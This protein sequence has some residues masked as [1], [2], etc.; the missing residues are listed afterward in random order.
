[1]VCEKI[2]SGIDMACTAYPRRYFQ[3]AVLVNRSDIEEK[4]ILTSYVNIDDEY[5]CRH[6]VLFK[7]FDG[8][9]GFRFKLGENASSIYGTAEKSI[10]NGIPQYAH[11]VNIAVLGVSEAS[12]CVLGQMDYS[13]YFVALQLYDGTVEIFGFEYGLTTEDYTYD[14]QN[15]GGGAVLKLASFE[16]SLEDELPFIYR[17]GTEGGENA[18]FDNL[19]LNNEFNVT[20]DFN[21][22]F[23]DDY[24]NQS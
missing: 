20:G 21:D 2:R 9:S 7:L 19:F 23:N 16:D 8:L 14:P 15:S 18:D 17:S 24:N 11:S 12:K 3:Q 22:D 6:R 5:H 13:D 10:E 1:M 4:A